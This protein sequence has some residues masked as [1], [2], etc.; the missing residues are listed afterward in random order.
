[1]GLGSV[2]GGVGWIGLVANEMVAYRVDE[3]MQRKIAAAY[4]LK[5]FGVNGGSRMRAVYEVAE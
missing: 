2:Y 3:G 4:E 5:N 1:M